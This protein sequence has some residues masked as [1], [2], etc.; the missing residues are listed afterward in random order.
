[1]RPRRAALLA[2]LTLLIVAGSPLLRAAELTIPPIPYHQRTLANGL[3]VLSVE[4]HASPNVAVQVWYH[5]GS[6][7]DPQGRSGFAHLFEH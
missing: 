6:K 7:D 2:S 4:D 1:M 3:Q 5:V